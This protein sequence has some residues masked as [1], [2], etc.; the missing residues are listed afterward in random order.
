M[1]NDISPHERIMK[2]KNVQDENIPN[3][4]V[5]LIESGKKAPKA[6]PLYSKGPVCIA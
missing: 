1:L 5:W 3:M 4:G 6:K 2:I